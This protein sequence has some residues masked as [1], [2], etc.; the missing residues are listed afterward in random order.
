MQGKIELFAAKIAAIYVVLTGVALI[1]FVPKLLMGAFYGVGTIIAIYQF[2]QKVKSDK[3]KNEYYQ[4][5]KDELKKKLNG[6]S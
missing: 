3:S 2:I 1:D 5:K 4:L 6:E